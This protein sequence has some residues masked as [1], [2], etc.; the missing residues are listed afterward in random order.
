MSEIPEYVRIW[1]GFRKLV[2]GF[3]E[4]LAK[5]LII[6][7]IRKSGVYV[8]GIWQH[9]VLSRHRQFEI[10]YINNNMSPRKTHQISIIIGQCYLV[11]SYGGTNRCENY[12]DDIMSG[13]A[14]KITGVSIVCSTVCSKKTPKL[15][16]TGHCRGNS[17][18]PVTRKIF[19]FPFD[20]VI[21][22]L[23]ALAFPDRQPVL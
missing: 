1:C 18:V 14:S 9:K 5:Y 23:S 2:W 7:V 17:P 10:V 20:D 15:R 13:V 22:K 8:N 11:R 16:I 21:V 3:I 12:N 6:K 19:P 4:W